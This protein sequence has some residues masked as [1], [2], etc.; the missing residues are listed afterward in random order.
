MI[1]PSP[2]QMESPA[3]SGLPATTPTE[4]PS[5]ATWPEVYAVL[6]VGVLPSLIVA[7]SC[8]ATPEVHDRYWVDA[9]TQ[10][11]TSLCMIYVTLYLIWRSGEPWLRFGIERRPD[12]SDVILGMGMFIASFAVVQTH[13]KISFLFGDGPTDR[14]FPKPKTEYDLCLMPVKF[15]TLAFSEELVT[16]AYLITRLEVLLRSSWKALL[17][18]AVAFASY[19]IYQGVNGVVFSLLFGLTFG[20]VFLIVRRI[21]PLVLGHAGYNAFYDLLD[22]YA[23]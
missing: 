7:L 18:S 23:R 2:A 5:S 16:R 10:T 13:Y 8:L 20:F 3:P 14:F 15:L 9:M 22:Y 1:D 21:W 11:G 17:F 19:H 12:I 4:V 6:A